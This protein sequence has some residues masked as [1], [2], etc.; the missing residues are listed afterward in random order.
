[1]EQNTEQLTEI[2]KEWKEKSPY[3]AVYFKERNRS[4]AKEPMLC[5]FQQF[6]MALYCGNGKTAKEQDLIMWK[7]NLKELDQLPVNAIE[8]LSFIEEQPDHY[9]SFIQLSELFFEWEKKSVILLKRKT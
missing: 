8:R 3:I 1:M 7:E 4:K 6:L 2:F 9:Q 5:F